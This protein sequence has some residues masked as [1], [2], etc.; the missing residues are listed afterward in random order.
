MGVLIPHLTGVA[1]SKPGPTIIFMSGFPDDHNSFQKVAPSF[2]SSHTI[3]R[4]NMPDYEKTKLTRFWGFPF[5]EI[6]ESLHEII[7]SV[8]NKRGQVCLVGHDWG[9][10]VSQLYI[11]RFPNTV[12]KLFL[13]DVGHVNPRK[14]SR[15]NLLIILA[16]QSWIVMSFLVG[17]V[18]TTL[19]GDLM[20]A[21]YPWSA[22]GPCPNDVNGVMPLKGTADMTTWWGRYTAGTH[23]WMGYPYFRR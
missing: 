12:D 21:F 1:T 11:S 23:C 9:S 7:L 6:L 14:T 17:R 16:Y 19:I 20:M 22:V 3:I 2:E 18:T 8:A 5:Y 15:S 13:L 4:I 10:F